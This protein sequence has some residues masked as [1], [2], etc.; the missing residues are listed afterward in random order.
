MCGEENVRKLSILSGLA[1]LAVSGLVLVSACD[2]KGAKQ[3]GIPIE[4]WKGPAYR[5]AFDAKA[6]KPNPKGVTIPA[7]KF[8]ANPDSLETRA[9]LVVKFD[10]PGAANKGLLQNH[11]I[12]AP[13]DIQG[14]E[15]ALPADYIE[16]ASKSLSAY[17]AGYCA[18][19]KVGI[20]VALARSSLNPTG[21]ESEIDAKLL[22]G[23][24]PTDIDLAKS[25]GK[26][27]K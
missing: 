2:S 25:H 16:S 26:C 3:P 1:L 24:L 19:G 5:L 20:S 9:I 6:T 21:N 23:W 7:I 8:T 27:S 17:L 15:G 18:D 4:K 22:S 10:V 12:A 11:M 14:A 13:V